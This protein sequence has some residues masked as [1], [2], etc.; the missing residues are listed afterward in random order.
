MD[1]SDI[2]LKNLI[3]DKYQSGLDLKYIIP[4]AVNNATGKEKVGKTK[5]KKIVCE[6]IY[7]YLM[8]Q[9]Q[10]VNKHI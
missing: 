8:K 1:I 2:Q 5:A 6:V 4:L 3:I 7:E 9:K 10:S